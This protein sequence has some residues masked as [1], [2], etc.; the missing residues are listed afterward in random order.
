MKKKITRNSK[1]EEYI[2]EVMFQA[3]ARNKNASIYN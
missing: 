1:V 3:F 2:N